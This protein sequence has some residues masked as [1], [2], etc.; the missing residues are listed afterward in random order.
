MPDDFMPL[1]SLSLCLSLCLS[2]SLSLYLSI[3]VSLSVSLSLPLYRLRCR[4]ASNV[5]A[6]T[7]SCWNSM[8][9]EPSS[10]WRDFQDI[11]YTCLSAGRIRQVPS[12]I[13]LAIEPSPPPLHGADPH[14][15]LQGDVG[16]A[17]RN[18]RRGA[19]KRLPAECEQLRVERVALHRSLTLSGSFK[20]RRLVFRAILEGKCDSCLFLLSFTP[21]FT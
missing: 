5:C 6:T 3:S 21:A 8:H 12:A 20:I 14:G 19:I 4:D 2:L 10:P 13:Q 18:G 9:A 16:L 11:M 17:E 15:L 1:S 7:H